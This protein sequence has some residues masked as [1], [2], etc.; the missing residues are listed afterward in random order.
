MNN[1]LET[2]TPPEKAEHIQ[3]PEYKELLT[4]M[5]RRYEKVGRNLPILEMELARLQMIADTIE[6]KTSFVKELYH[7]LKTLHPFYRSLIFL[8]FDENKVYKYIECV[9][10]ARK[11]AQYFAKKYRYILMAQEERKTIKKKASEAR[12]RMLSPIK[13]CSKGLLYLKNLVVYLS[14]LPG[15]NP[16]LPTI[17]V[18]GPPSVGKSSFVA[19]ASRARINIAEYPF[20]TREI[21]VG[22]TNIRGKDIQ[23]I[24]TPG[25]LDRKLEER[26]EIELKAIMALKHLTGIVIFL[27]D[28]TETASYPI[29]VQLEIADDVKS[30]TGNK[31]FV[32]TISKIDLVSRKTLS[33]TH[34][35]IKAKAGVTPYSVKASDPQSVHKLLEELVDK[36]SG[37]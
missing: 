34:E 22:H 12:G 2:I 33:N 1:R 11:I 13:R 23:L 19:S 15:I 35:L 36:C 24:D 17:I 20:T 29:G 18:A 32:Y 7:L 3:V 4:R 25:L 14:H 31:P 5:K 37:E 10:K 27:L 21:H 8:E 9:F 6:S 30:I 26:N 16:S 28:P